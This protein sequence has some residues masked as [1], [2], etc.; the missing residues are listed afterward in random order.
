MKRKEDRVQN[1]AINNGSLRQMLTF[2]LGAEVYGVDILQV[3]EIRGWSPV[4]R[5]PQSPP[6]V[7]GVLNLR[8]AIVPVVDLRVLFS[9]PTA[10][11]TPLTVVIILSL[12]GP[13]GT[14][15]C[16][17]V[18]D[19]VKDVVDVPADG[20]RPAPTMNEAGCVFIQGIATV[21]EQMLILLDANEL[22][23]RDL[24]PDQPASTAA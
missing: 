8:G 2:A 5:M 12:R 11:F 16:G 7:L 9:L 21:D 1:A 19:N 3:K 4:T 6:S 13:H 22:I 23:P 20:I 10:A 17:V 15:E 14:R 24:A 18:V